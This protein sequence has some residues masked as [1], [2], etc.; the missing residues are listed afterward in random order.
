MVQLYWGSALLTSEL[1]LSQ[2]FQVVTLI[3]VIEHIYLEDLPQLEQNVFYYLRPEYVIVTT[4]NRDFNVYFAKS[5]TDELFRHPDHKY[6]FTRAEFEDWSTCVSL[7]Y[8]YDLQYE[9][10]GPHKIYGTKNGCCSQGV[11][12]TRKSPHKCMKPDI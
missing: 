6:E 4:P 12:F 5:S 2:H 1:L 3:E 10:I 8:G 7:K 11:L 9:G